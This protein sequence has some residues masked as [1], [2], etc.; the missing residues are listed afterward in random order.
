M[1]IVGDTAL[2][3]PALLAECK[4]LL[5]GAGQSSRLE[6]I[7]RRKQEIGERHRQLRAKWQAFAEESTKVQGSI[8]PAYM[9]KVTNDVLRG[10]NWEIA[11]GDLG[12]WARRMMDWDQP[13]CW[14]GRSGGGGLG[15]QLGATIGA[16]LAH[17]D[18]KKL[19]VSFQA[20]GDFLFTPQAL[21]TAAKYQTPALV[22]MDNNRTYYNSQNHAREVAEHRNR[23]VENQGI[24]TEIQG[25][26]VDF[27]NLAKSFGCDAIGPI[28][29]PRQLESALR[30]GVRQVK[31]GKFVVVD[32]RTRH[33]GHK[34]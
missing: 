26:D 23:P 13:N 5:A 34:Q 20:D 32:V 1:H 24:G 2:A 25:P 16:S 27:V 18:G 7:E 31:E 3:L 15:Y 6:A 30:E 19:V 28:D 33:L 8:H 4:E 14:Q 22:I 21:W 17:S 29:D 12:G 10:E 9:A 11:N